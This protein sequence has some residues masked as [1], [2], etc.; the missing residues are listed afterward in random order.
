MVDITEVD[1]ELKIKQ[2]QDA[3]RSIKGAILAGIL[4]MLV[5]LIVLLNLVDKAGNVTISKSIAEVNELVLVDKEGKVRSRLYIGKEN[6]A[7]Q[8]FYDTDGKKRIVHGV[9]SDGTA[10]HR[11]FDEYEKPRVS[12][13]VFKRGVQ[14]SIVGISI[15]GENEKPSINLVT[16][17][18]ADTKSKR[19]EISLLDDKGKFSWQASNSSG[20]TSISVYDE[21][22]EMRIN[23]YISD[24]YSFRHISDENGKLRITHGTIGNKALGVYRDENMNERLYMSVVGSGSSSYLGYSKTGKEIYAMGVDK[25]NKV[26]NFQ[27]ETA[28]QKALNFASIFGTILGVGQVLFSDNK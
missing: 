15:F 6:E 24:N 28:S 20:S 9:L 13:S 5:V 22:G 23:D 8:E 1:I 10:R 2:L 17:D 3:H 19:S 4:L 21:N 11:L 16:Y 25:N 12:S 14:N 27:E 26:I 7:V 18:N